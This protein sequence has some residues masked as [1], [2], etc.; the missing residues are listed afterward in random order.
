M[1]NKQVNN[2]RAYLT[3]LFN[4]KLI[5]V[6]IIQIRKMIRY[7][8]TSRFLKVPISNRSGNC[9]LESWIQSANARDEKVMKSAQ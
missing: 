2:A 4:H 8:N 5:K 7:S 1:K 9:D 3:V 6:C